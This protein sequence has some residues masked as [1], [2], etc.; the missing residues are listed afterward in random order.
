[1]KGEAAALQLL[2]DPLFKKMTQLGDELYEMELRP[3][4]V[5]EN[6][7]VVVG[8]NILCLAKKLLLDFHYS[9][10]ARMFMTTMY[11]TVST[12]TDSLYVGLGS[13]SLLENVRPEL[14]QLFIQQMEGHHETPDDQLIPGQNVSYLG[15]TCCELHKRKD[16]L[17]P[18]FWKLEWS[19]TGLVALSSKTLCGKGP[20][21][22]ATKVTCKGLQKKR[23]SDPYQTYMSVL[24]SS[25]P[26]GV[27]NYGFRQFGKSMYTYSVYKEGLKTNYWKRCIQ[28]D[29][30]SSLPLEL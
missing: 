7:P 11:K 25:R 29:G 9:F 22:N 30:I 13:Q 19:G 27:R 28:P 1:M 10:V 15:R 2:R 4:H 20:D 12:D 16:A 18:G 14:R 21:G 24:K 5:V 3:R 8:L 17:T 23:L 26:Q 6:L